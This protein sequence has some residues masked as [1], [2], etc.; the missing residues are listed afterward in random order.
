VAIDEVYY[1]KL[2]EE[3]TLV[4][5]LVDVDTQGYFSKLHTSIVMLP[6]EDAI[7]AKELAKRENLSVS[8][9]LSQTLRMQL[10][11]S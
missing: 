6:Y 5:P 9:Y 11:A 4:D 7:I 10:T 8:E 2:D 3:L 1:D